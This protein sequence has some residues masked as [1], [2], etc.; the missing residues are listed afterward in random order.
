LVGGMLKVISTAAA[1]KG[2]LKKERILQSSVDD[3][4]LAWPLCMFAHL[5]IL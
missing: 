2:T 4:R 1:N 3:G 5:V